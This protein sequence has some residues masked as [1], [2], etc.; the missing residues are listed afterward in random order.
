VAKAALT[1]SRSNA[2]PERGFSVN[3]AM[4]G[5][6]KLALAENTIVAQRVVKDCVRIFGSVTN[7]PITKDVIAAARR[8]YT[9]YCVHLEEQ[10]RQ[11]AAELQRQAELKKQQED[12]RQLQKQKASLMEQLAEKDQE[13]Q[14]QQREHDTAKELIN[15]ATNKMAAAVEL[16]NMQSVK[17]AQMKLKAGN[18]KL[19]ETSKKLET[20]GAKQRDLRK[21]LHDHDMKDVTPAKKMKT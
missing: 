1:L 7:V 12:K 14:E 16:K 18:E 6:E 19:Q 11:Q 2:I 8:A 17:V 20:I 9:E 15:E 4:L 5:K 13:E 3:N 10:K 21:R